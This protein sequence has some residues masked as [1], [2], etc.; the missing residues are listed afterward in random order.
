[1]RLDRR[2]TK[3]SQSLRQRPGSGCQAIRLSVEVSNKRPS[4]LTRRE[5]IHGDE[6]EINQVRSFEALLLCYLYTSVLHG[7][8]TG[9]CS[10]LISSTSQPTQPDRFQFFFISSTSSR[11]MWC[12]CSRCI[13][14]SSVCITTF[15]LNF[16]SATT[17]A[18]IIPCEFC[19][20]ASA[21]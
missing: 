5:T 11:D 21:K 18:S 8:K 7:T 10:S 9:T 6:L 20:Q 3:G 2:A 14:S 12:S 19:P 17:W 16:S 13:I 15:P 1:M 4:E